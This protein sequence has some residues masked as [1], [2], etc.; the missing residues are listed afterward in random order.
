MKPSGVDEEQEN[1]KKKNCLKIFMWYVLFEVKYAHD[2]N[3]VQNLR[4]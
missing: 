4:V 2:S 1:E 3:I